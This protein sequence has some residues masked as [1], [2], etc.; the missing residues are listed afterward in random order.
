MVSIA[1]ASWALAALVGLHSGLSAAQPDRLIVRF[2]DK[3]ADAAGVVAAADQRIARAVASVG[4]EHL[5]EMQRRRTLATGAELFEAKWSGI[6]DRDRVIEQLRKAPGI[7]YVEVDAR[8]QPAAVPND[9]RYAEQWH[10]FE[11]AGG[12]NLPGAWDRSTG[13]GVVVAV[14]DTGERPHPDLLANLVQGVDLIGDLSTANDGNGRDNN[15]ADPGDWVEVGECNSTSFIPSS[16]HGTHVAGTVAAVANNALDGTGVAPSARVASVRALGKCGGFTSD[17]ADGIVWAAGGSVAGVRDNPN[18]A[19]VINMSLGGG[20]SCSQTEQEAIDFAV[21]RSV[22]ITVAAGNDNSDA[23]QFSPASCRNVITVAATGRSGERAFYSNF[24][25]AIDVAAPG[26]AQGPEANGVLS[27]LNGGRRGPREDILAFYQG[28]SMAAPH[29]AGVVALM[30]AVRPDLT[31]LQAECVL[32]QTVRSFPANPDRP[33]GPGIVDAEAAVSFVATQ[34]TLPEDCDQVVVTELVFDQAVG[35]LAGTAGEQRFFRIAV[36]PGSS[37]LRVVFDVSGGDPDLYVRQGSLPTLS[38][39]DCRPYEP[40]G[41]D[42]RCEFSNPAA[43]DWFIMIDAYSSYDG[44]SLLVSRTATNAPTTIGF[45][46]DSARVREGRT[47]A[48]TITLDSPATVR[49]RV[50]L[51]ASGTA[52]LGEDFTLPSAV[53]IPVGTQE[54]SVGLS[55]IQDGLTEEPERAVVRLRAPEGL[56]VTN[57]RVAVRILDP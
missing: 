26:G 50:P 33:I 38:D 22:A 24:G 13:E 16:W 5:V 55:A 27:T 56:T 51:R 40:T 48:F 28:T 8:R 15:P 17:I 9:P 20:G 21:N 41:I 54:V 7:R 18:P 42:E 31:A 53:I 32:Q 49:M 10:Y 19:Q 29:I 44:A 39:F 47:V 43:G 4:A 36:P 57:G 12:L 3:S 35:P 45:T 34:A 25:T 46:T 30:R 1:R 52:V 37:L 23:S 11:A 2:S 14:I 6:V